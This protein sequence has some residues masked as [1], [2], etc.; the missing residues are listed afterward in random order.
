MTTLHSTA[1]SQQAAGSCRI[2]PYC[3]WAFCGGRRRGPGLLGILWGRGLRRMRR[4]RKSQG[5]A[6]PGGC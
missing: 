1:G 5:G 2:V 3:P 6:P 4:L